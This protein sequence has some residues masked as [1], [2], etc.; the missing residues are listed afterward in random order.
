MNI[1]ITTPYDEETKQIQDFHGQ[2]QALEVIK[3]NE[4]ALTKNED[5]QYNEEYPLA[6]KLVLPGD[7]VLERKDTDRFLRGTGLYE[8]DGNYYS[9]ILG[10]VNYINKLIY[11]SPVKGKYNAATGDLLVGKIK[12]IHNDKWIVDIGS[13]TKAFLAISQTNIGEFGQRIRVYNDILNMINIYKPNDIVACEVQKVQSDG[14]IILHTRST[15]Y[16]KLSNGVLITVPQILV[17]SQKKHIFVFPCNVQIILGMNGCIWVSS[18]IKKVKDTNPNSIDEEIEGDKFEEIDS[19]M[20]K[21]ISIISNIIK[22][23]AKY[24]INMNYDLITKIYGDYVKTHG[25]NPA[26]FLKPYVAEYYLFNYINKVHNMKNA[27]E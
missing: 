16:G 10:T 20:R 8:E 4:N 15:I 19:T 1:L 22:L 7:L 21:N 27:T 9:C 13:P 24:H 25:V 6:K 2:L 18:P 5:A 14:S 17:Q 23:L 11:I 12:D 26:A 3:E